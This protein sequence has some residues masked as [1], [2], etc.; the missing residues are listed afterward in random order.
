MTRT[1]IIPP[2][3]PPTMAPMGV[4][5]LVLASKEPPVDEGDVVD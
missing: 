1:P 5:L 3:T 4:D 2:T